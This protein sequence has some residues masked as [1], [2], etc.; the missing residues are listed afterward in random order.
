MLSLYPL[1][2]VSSESV[3]GLPLYTSKHEHLEVVCQ[4]KGL[5]TPCSPLQKWRC[6]HDGFRSDENTWYWMLEH[7]DSSM[8][9]ITTI[10]IYGNLYIIP[11]S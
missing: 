8:S 11:N 5:Q 2:A 1:N 4:N 3:E 7:F 9:S 10:I 6:Q